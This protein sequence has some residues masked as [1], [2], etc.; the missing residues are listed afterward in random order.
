MK[1]NNTLSL[2][3]LLLSSKLTR[4]KLDSSLCIPLGNLEALFPSCEK[5]DLPLVLSKAL[6]GAQVIVSQ[7]NNVKDNM[8]KV[9]FPKDCNPLPA[10]KASRAFLELLYDY[11]SCFYIKFSHYNQLSLYRSTVGLPESEF[12]KQIKYLTVFPF[13]KYL[14]NPVEESK[15]QNPFLFTGKVKN[16]LSRRIMGSHSAKTTR[17]WWSW[18]QG[19]KRGCEYADKIYVEEAYEKHRKSLDSNPPITSEYFLPNFRRKVDQFTRGFHAEE[20]L[21]QISSSACYESTRSDGGALTYI[22]GEHNDLVSLDSLPNSVAYEFL[23]MSEWKGRVRSHYG[24]VAPNLKQLIS[25]CKLNTHNH[26]KVQAILEPLKVRMVTKG[27]AWAY[28]YSKYFQKAMWN[29]LQGFSQFEATGRPMDSDF[30]YRMIEKQR[31][32]GFEFDSFLSGDYSAATDKISIT[33]TKIVM[34]SFL[35]RCKSLSEDRKEI[36]RRVIYEQV[37]EYPERLGDKI[38][39]IPDLDQ[40][41]GQ[42]MGSTLSF[43]ILCIVNL[44][45]YWMALE[46]GHLEEVPLEK[47]PVIVNG[48][49]ILFPTNDDVHRNWTNMIKD[50]GF[51]LSIGKNYR[52][53]RYLTVNSLLF[54]FVD[55]RVSEINYFNVGLLTGQSKLGQAKMGGINSLKDCYNKVMEGAQNKLRAHSRFIYYNKAQLPSSETNW[56]ISDQLG[57]LGFNLY[58]EIEPYVHVNHYH[59]C[60][61]SAIKRTVGEGS[62]PS[63]GYITKGGSGNISIEKEHQYSSL[64]W[65]RIFHTPREKEF[66]VEPDS[67]MILN[68]GLLSE[69]NMVFKPF[70]RKLVEKNRPSKLKDI[71]NIRYN[72]WAMRKDPY[73][74]DDEI[75]VIR[76]LENNFDNC[77]NSSSELQQRDIGQQIGHSITLECLD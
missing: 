40:R 35:S 77:R 9:I 70:P 30:I 54:E 43:P 5:G 6:G 20:E 12:L 34:E 22:L 75:S 69:G 57:G 74:K 52:H 21:Y 42:L 26:V 19:A 61:I 33:C 37:I 50:A 39:N 18:L 58:P 16:Y 72:L 36:L 46:V 60:V 67:R 53:R 76:T 28:W 17:L 1:T 11:D 68:S 24:L 73:A 55:D 63:Y 64:K 41:N 25:Y 38:L 4:S 66:L 44:V 49:D 59:R 13:A 48:D 65:R 47:L 62:C 15:S 8:C 2:V 45:C 10:L 7:K 56:F 71:I 27:N 51:E 32:L 31:K 29:H 23:F 3:N 14:D